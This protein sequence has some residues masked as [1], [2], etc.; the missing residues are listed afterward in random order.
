MNSVPFS[1]L[2]LASTLAAL[3][4][5]VIPITL[6]SPRFTCNY[7]CISPT[8]LPICDYRCD[9]ASEPF[10]AADPYLC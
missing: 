10:A 9:T 3:L 5:L 1:R 2:V 6:P 8:T 7:C 4:M